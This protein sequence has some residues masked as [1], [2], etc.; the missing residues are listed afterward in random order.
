M[1]LAYVQFADAHP[2]HYR[3]MFGRYIESCS[4]DQEFVQEARA[5]FG[6][7]VNSIVEQQQL[8]LVRKDDPQ[9]VALFI[10]SV[11]HGI[12]MLV[13]DGQLRGRDDHGE[14]LNTYARER[15]RAA[16]SA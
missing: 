11:V 6:V 9:L 14:T 7:L 8:G 15:I 4:K 3:V 16:I 10:W 2:S 1:G 12:A 5:A 13:I